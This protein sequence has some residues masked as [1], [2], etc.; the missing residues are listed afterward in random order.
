MHYRDRLLNA[1]AR[2]FT[3]GMRYQQ[4]ATSL[5]AEGR[6]T[7]NPTK[8]QMKNANKAHMSKITTP[9]VWRKRSAWD[10]FASK[11]PPREWDGT[12]R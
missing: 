10:R 9:K 8:K 4:T 5:F 7:D 3:D 6:K 2:G 11:Y 1:Y 12:N